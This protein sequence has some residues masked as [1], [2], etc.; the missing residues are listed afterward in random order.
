M[1]NSIKKILVSEKSFQAAA[2]GKYSFIVAKKV[3]KEDVSK[4][5]ERLFGVT[6]LSANSMNYKGKIKT[7][8]RKEGKR[9]DFKKVILTLKKGDKI[10]LF[11]IEGEKKEEKPKKEKKTKEQK[12]E[13]AAS[14]GMRGNKDVEVTIKSK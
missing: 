6:V 9:N 1:N 11:E 14:E 13:D 3:G 7:V 4:L 8:K 10:D 5:C 2:G 12:K